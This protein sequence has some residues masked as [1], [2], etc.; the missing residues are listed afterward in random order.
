VDQPQA[1]SEVMPQYIGY[2]PL[3]AMTY[4]AVWV[5]LLYFL[6]KVKWA[7]I[8]YWWRQFNCFFEL[9]CTGAYTISYFT[10]LKWVCVWGM[11]V[12]TSAEQ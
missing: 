3:T 2:W 11:T 10:L 6:S 5:L 8:I 12:E 7:G 9:K 4:P 1:V